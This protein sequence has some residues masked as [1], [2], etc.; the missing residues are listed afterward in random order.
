[1]RTR[2]RSCLCCAGAGSGSGSGRRANPGCC[3]GS[4]LYEADG[5]LT[6]VKIEM[7]LSVA[8]CSHLG[9]CVSQYA[10]DDEGAAGPPVRTASSSANWRS[11]SVCADMS[12]PAEFT[13][14]VDGGTAVALANLTCEE[15]WDGLVVGS[16]TVDLT[17]DSYQVTAGF[18]CFQPNGPE[19]PGCALYPDGRIYFCARV[20]F[21][22]GH[23]YAADGVPWGTLPLADRRPYWTAWFY[24]DVTDM[25][26]ADCDPLIFSVNNLAPYLV[27][28]LDGAD[29]A[30]LIG[31]VVNTVPLTKKCPNIRISATVTGVRL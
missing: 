27:E 5:G 23:D 29:V 26:L 12:L 4:S 15:H 9:S 22:Q 2:V 19:N 30:N 13:G 17:Q 3:A 14:C 16:P 6:G 1:M 11:D 18:T 21:M 8:N 31:P 20:A 28:E 25:L 7:S 24:Q 10:Y